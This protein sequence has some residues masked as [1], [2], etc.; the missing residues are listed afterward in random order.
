[1]AQDTTEYSYAKYMQELKPCQCGKIPRVYCNGYAFKVICDTEDCAQKPVS[2]K[3][4]KLAINK[5]NVKKALEGINENGN[6]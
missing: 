1:M 5:W 6:V 4:E 3:T 2:A